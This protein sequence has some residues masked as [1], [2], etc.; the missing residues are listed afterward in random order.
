[1]SL[2][3]DALRKLEREK[4]GRAPGILVVGSVPWGETSRARRF[5]LVGVA[6]VALAL[7]VAVGWLLRPTQATPAAKA[8][9][10]AAEPT[11]AA[12]PAATPALPTAT[13]PPRGRRRPPALG[14]ADPA[15]PAG[16]PARHSPPARRGSGCVECRRS[17]RALGIPT[18]GA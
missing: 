12:R 2:I 7:A 3:L 8:P 13:P 18:R 15:R 16:R 5:V 14:S 10:P 6:V 1:M 17:S 4:E 9:P 11:R